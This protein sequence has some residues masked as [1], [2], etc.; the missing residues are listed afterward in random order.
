MSDPITD[1]AIKL[2]LTPEWN[3]L[4]A[5]V[6]TP[7]S[8]KPA[9]APVSHAQPAQPTVPTNTLRY[10]FVQAK[11]HS[12]RAGAKIQG[13]LLHA[14]EGHFASD[15]DVLTHGRKEADG[16]ITPV[17]THW[18]IDRSGAY[19]HLVDDSEKANHA[20]NVNDPRFSNAHSIGIEMVRLAPEDYPAVQV[21]ACAELAA[22]LMQKHGELAIG[23]HK[24]V[25]IPKGRK[26]DPAGFPT[27]LFQTLLVEAKKTKWTAEQI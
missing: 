1:A 15:L 6:H 20:G 14:T 10:H 21:K 25:A 27:G 11:Y 16:S 18:L 24:D 17:S 19:W 2:V 26:S 13:I 4:H 3:A 7:I 5:L 9:E 22:F 12:S 8:S 23:Y